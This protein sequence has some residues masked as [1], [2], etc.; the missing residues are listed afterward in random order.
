MHVV[1]DL[2]HSPVWTITPRT[3]HPEIE[4]LM[5]EHAIRH[6]PVLD[7]GRLVGMVSRGDLR[8]ARPSD[9]T[10]LSRHEQQS[11]LDQLTAADVMTRS[12][13]TVAARSPLS[14]AAELML[15]HKISSLAV[16]D[17]GRLVGMITASDLF[18]AVI[19]GQPPRLTAVVTE[20]DRPRPHRQH[21]IV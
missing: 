6:L 2:M 8:Q 15:A 7:R 18:A 17:G 5:Q 16:L 12:V 9:A 1:R 14:L 19:D 21:P 13:V 4:R 3:C 11:A 20:Q 10:T